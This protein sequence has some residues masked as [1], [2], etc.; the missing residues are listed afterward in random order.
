VARQIGGARQSRAVA[1]ILD[2][3]REFIRKEAAESKRE[4]KSSEQDAWR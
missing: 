1:E 3:L 4:P 2:D